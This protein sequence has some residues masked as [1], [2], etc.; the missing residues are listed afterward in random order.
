MSE[1]GSSFT[2]SPYNIIYWATTN[3]PSDSYIDE[4]DTVSSDDA[5][6]PVTVP[7][8]LQPILE[9]LIGSGCVKGQEDI[10][11]A[12]LDTDSKVTR[13]YPSGYDEFGISSNFTVSA[14]GV[15]DGEFR[16]TKDL[17][18]NSADASPVGIQKTLNALV[19]DDY[20][21]ARQ[22]KITTE[23]DL[24][25]SRA[26]ART[27]A[28]I[29]RIMGFA[30]NLNGKTYKVDAS[31]DMNGKSIYS[32]AN[33]ILGVKVE[34]EG[35]MI[36]K[37]KIAFLHKGIESSNLTCIAKDDLIIQTVP[38]SKY[39]IKGY[40]YSAD[41]VSIEG[42]DPLGAL[43]GAVIIPGSDD[44]EPNM[45]IN[46]SIIG[47]NCNTGTDNYGNESI[48]I[49]NDKNKIFT[50]GSYGWSSLTSMRGGYF[51]VRRMSWF[52]LN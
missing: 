10:G 46:G 12:Q 28:D 42:F 24:G 25:D 14:D 20:K 45:Y 21:T 34:G 30:Y 2:L 52:E 32:N 37:G 13:F 16:L 38:G 39:K 49:K 43:A 19:T 3:E 40:L 50:Y 22:W 29:F 15:I 33:L 27:D 18:I 47:L 35:A 23:T 11:L 5:N 8:Q 51:H 9:S 44:L 4:S 36:S 26:A 31:M 6:T 7:L 41:D 17:Y 48:R 1:S